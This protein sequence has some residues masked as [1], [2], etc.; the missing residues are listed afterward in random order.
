MSDMLMSE[1]ALYNSNLNLWGNND[2]GD[3]CTGNWFY[4]CDRFGS[5][6]NILNPIT[7]ARLRTAQDFAFKSVLFILILNELYIYIV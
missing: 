1:E 7:S 6:D 5:A 2:R 3:V 4:G